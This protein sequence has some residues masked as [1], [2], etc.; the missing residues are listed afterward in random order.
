MYSRCPDVSV[1]PAAEETSELAEPAESRQLQ[2]PTEGHLSVALSSSSNMYHS[3]PD[4]QSSLTNVYTT[5]NK[6]GRF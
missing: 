6:A 2:C 3:Y 1:T 5:G 4:E